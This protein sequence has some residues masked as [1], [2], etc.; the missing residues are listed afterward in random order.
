MYI[1][2]A[3]L[4]I[5]WRSPFCAALNAEVGRWGGKIAVCV[6][7][8]LQ[9]NVL[10]SHAQYNTMPSY[11]DWLTELL[12]SHSCSTWHLFFSRNFNSSG[13][14]TAANHQTQSNYL[15]FGV[16]LGQLTRPSPGAAHSHIW[17]AWNRLHGTTA[18]R[19][20]TQQSRHLAGKCERSAPVKQSQ[21]VIRRRHWVWLSAT[22]SL[23]YSSCICL[24]WNC[25][26]HGQLALPNTGDTEFCCSVQIQC[27]P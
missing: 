7:A 2:W 21:P 20:L 11:E 16:A 5:G 13:R 17:R 24:T 3:F 19:R 26:G 10:I 8:R 12:I 25:I 9:L 4:V 6:M 1:D 23:L 27:K 15:H 22:T 18:W 14:K